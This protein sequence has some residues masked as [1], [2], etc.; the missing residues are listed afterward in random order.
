MGATQILKPAFHA[1]YDSVYSGRFL[2]SKKASKLFAIAS[3]S[4]A[5]E[6]VFYHPARS[7]GREE[8]E[9][10][11]KPSL[12]K[13]T[14]QTGTRLPMEEPSAGAGTELAVRDDKGRKAGHRRR[15]FRRACKICRDAIFK[16][17]RCIWLC[18]QEQKE[19]AALCLS[20]LLSSLSFLSR[21]DSIWIFNDTSATKV[22]VG[23]LYRESSFTLIFFHGFAQT[24]APRVD[25]MPSDFS[26]ETVPTDR[27]VKSPNLRLKKWWRVRKVCIFFW[28]RVVDQ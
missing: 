2:G 28:W 12:K 18:R 23:W 9:T 5:E 4:Q 11:Q 20:P 3:L 19:A 1:T 24:S 10:I 22:S 15:F 14:S 26:N 8:I 25:R 16:P 27:S 17:R 21:S 13:E 7:V 6:S